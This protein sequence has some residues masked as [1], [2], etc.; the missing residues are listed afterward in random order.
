M[1]VENSM[2]GLQKFGSLIYRLL[3]LNVLFVVGSLP[4]FTIGTSFTALLACIEDESKSFI[5][6]YKQ[7]FKASQKMTWLMLPL[8]AGVVFAS[9]QPNIISLVLMYEIFG[10]FVVSCQL[11]VHYSLPLLELM[12]NS[13]IVVNRLYGHILLIMITG[14]ALL[15]VGQRIPVIGIFM[16]FSIWSYLIVKIMH[17]GLEKIF[18]EVA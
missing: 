10:V 9:Q 11:I 1:N 6:E 13:F 14:Y 5:S 7:H 3:Y 2:R 17:H 4:L 18:K 8:I 12:K 15:K 16:F